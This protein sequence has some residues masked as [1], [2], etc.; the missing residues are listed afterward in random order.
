MTVLEDALG[1]AE[2]GGWFEPWMDEA[3]CAQTDPEL[4]FPEK[5][6]S[7]KLAKKICA[8]CPVAAQCLEFALRNDD[9]FGVFGGLSERE[10]RKLRPRRVH[11][12][13]SAAGQLGALASARSRGRMA[14]A[15]SAADDDRLRVM[16][17]A[18]DGDV[19]I[20]RALGVSRAAVVKRRARLRLL[21]KSWTR[22][23]VDA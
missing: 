3:A 1:A 16:F 21:R 14:H 8:G 19:A 11:V 20:A 17:E 7:A 12:G 18:G 2:P 9:R 10:R 13:R 15:W 6:A 23:A 4:F 5:G 22:R